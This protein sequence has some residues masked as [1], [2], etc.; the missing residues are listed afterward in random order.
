MAD[1]KTYR[2]L[3]QYPD[4]AI[5]LGS[6]GLRL[7]FKNFRYSTN[8]EK[9]QKIIERSERFRNERIVLEQGNSKPESRGPETATS[10]ISTAMGRKPKKVQVSEEVKNENA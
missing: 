8:V 2:N 4:E 5:T 10:A 1:L 7:E 3:S 6:G 9:I